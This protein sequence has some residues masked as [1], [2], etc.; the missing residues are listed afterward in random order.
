[1]VCPVN[2]VREKLARFPK[3]QLGHHPTPLEPL[4][5]LEAD[6][7]QKHLFVKRD[8]CN[9][10]VFGGNKVRQLEYYLGE[11]L[12]QK[13]DHILITGAVQSNFVRLAAAAAN[14]L[15]MQCHIQLE[16]RVAGKSETYN[17]SGNVLLDKM[18]GAKIYH[19]PHGEDEEGADDRLHEIAD[20]LKHKGH[21]PYVIHLAPGHLPM[22]ALG[23]VDAAC[24]FVEQT[25]QQQIDFD[26][27]VVPSGSGNTHCGLLFGLRAMGV[28]TPVSGI[29]VRRGATEQKQRLIA[30]CSELSQMLEIDN[31]V[32]ESDIDLNDAFLPPAYGQL[33]DA[34]NTAI[35]IAATKEALILDPVYSGKTMAGFLQIAKTMPSGSTILFWHTGGAPAVFAYQQ[36]LSV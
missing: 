3:A 22:G 32:L 31:P 4:K 27:I 9:G 36:E 24:E 29:C 18:L 16:Q 12:A 15:G 19:Y 26:K 11:A 1:M 33:N 17:T 23:Y 14:K 7:P 25:K 34:T 21:R 28:R 8:D 10:L 13:A 35:N 20:E 2:N 6:F 5:N 30:R